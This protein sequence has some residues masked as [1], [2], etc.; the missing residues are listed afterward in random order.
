MSE[1]DEERTPV[2]AALELFVYAPVG[3]A[4]EARTLLPRF[5]QRG[6]SQIALARV[7]GKFAVRKG[8]EDLEAAVVNGQSHVIGTLRSVGVV[9]PSS[10]P[11]SDEVT[12]A[13]QRPSSAPRVAAVRPVPDVDPASLAIPGYDTLSASQV[14]PRL[15]S[16]T[17]EEL[18]LVRRYEAAA[19]GRKTILSKIAQLQSS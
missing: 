6:R 19:R 12:P 16:L 1:P 9:P 13:P 14:I 11:T 17:T 5:V 15:A 2:D 7:V 3:L 18:E 8:R 10:E 4:L